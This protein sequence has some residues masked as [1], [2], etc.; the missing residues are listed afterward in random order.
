MNDNELMTAVR[1]SFTDVRSA[2]AVERIVSRSRAIRR[3]RRVRGVT[4]AVGPAVAVGVALPASLPATSHA[5][6]GPGVRLAAWT[7]TRQT[8][9]SI[10]V[11][12]F[13]ELRDP[14][15]LQ[16]MLRADG[17]PASV[18]FIGQLN[19]ARQPY[20]GSASPHWPPSSGE[21]LTGPLSGVL[22]SS[23]PQDAFNT[24]DALVIQPAALPAGAG[25]QIAVMK[26]IPLGPS[27]LK[28]ALVR[29]AIPVL[30]RAAGLRGAAAG[31]PA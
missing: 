9:G 23:S 5:A 3:R 20:A 17:V 4:A 13:G 25:L 16:A 19:P 15:T 7:V 2:T 31:L 26:G 8:G 22:G 18:T 6:R 27:G 14:A 21:P 10:Q 11:S 30:I 29:T 12:F 24:Q 28:L 1:E